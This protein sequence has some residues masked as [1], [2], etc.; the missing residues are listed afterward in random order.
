LSNLIKEGWQLFAGTRA[1]L[2]LKTALVTYRQNSIIKSERYIAG[3]IAQ[4]TEPREKKLRHT[5]EREGEG[6]PKY[7][8]G[9]NTKRGLIIILKEKTL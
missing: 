9:T 2:M 6:G 8:N 4:Q 7:R 1:A 5:N 3:E